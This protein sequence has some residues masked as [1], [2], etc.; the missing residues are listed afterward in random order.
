M[1]ITKK[2]H[3]EISKNK[4]FLSNNIQEFTIDFLFPNI[5]QTM[6]YMKDKELIMASRNVLNL[7]QISVQLLHMSR[8]N[9]FLV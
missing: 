6:E 8:L 4:S 7:V 9:V 1:I 3:I 2:N 5:M